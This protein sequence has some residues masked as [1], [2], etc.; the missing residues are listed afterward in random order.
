MW[1]ASGWSSNTRD[2]EL[3]T[4]IWY[5]CLYIEDFPTI[6]MVII[7]FMWIFADMAPIYSIPQCRCEGTKIC[8]CGPTDY[9]KY[10][11]CCIDIIFTCKYGQFHFTV[12]WIMKEVMSLSQ[13]Q[14]FWILIVTNYCHNFTSKMQDRTFSQRENMLQ[15]VGHDQRYYMERKDWPYC[16][17]CYI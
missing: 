14:P 4:L 10:N 15:F 6:W 8:G 3:E 17:M 7:I 5:T 11:F 1:K 9:L 16:D 2:Q 13:L 12:P